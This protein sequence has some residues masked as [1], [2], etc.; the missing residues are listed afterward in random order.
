MNLPLLQFIAATF[1]M[2]V[3]LF[4]SAAIFVIGV[5]LGANLAQPARDE[6]GAQTPELDLSNASELDRAI[7]SSSARSSADGNV[8]PVPILLK[9][10]T[11]VESTVPVP[12]PS[13]NVP[14]EVNVMPGLPAPELRSRFGWR[15]W[16][17]RDVPNVS[18]QVGAKVSLLS[19]LFEWCIVLFCVWLFSIGFLTLGTQNPLSG[20]ESEIFQSLDWV[21]VNNLKNF[22][23]FPQWNPYIL[24]GLPYVGDPFLHLFNPLVTVPVLLMGV[25][26]GF[27]VG[28]FLSFVAAAFGAW[29]LGKVMG[30]GRT[31]RVFLALSYAF[32]GRAVAQFLQGQYD[33]IFSFSWIPLCIAGYIAAAETR[34]PFHVALTALAL[35][36]LFLSGNVYYTFYMIFV[37]GLFV[38]VYVLRV[39]RKPF[40]LQLN[41]DV[42]RALVIAGFLAVALSAVQLL[43][44]LQVWPNLQKQGDPTLKSSHTLSQVWLDYTS[45]QIERADTKYFAQETYSYIGYIPFVGLLLLPLAWFKQKRRV[46]V[47]MLL[48]FI[49]AVMWASGRETPL[50]AF[51]ESS[52]FLTQFR[53]PTRF[54]LYG[55]L[56]L[57][58]LT[59]LGLDSVLRFLPV[60]KWSAPCEKK[61]SGS[62]VAVATGVLL[63]LALMFWSVADVYMNNKRLAITLNVYEPAWRTAQAL[64][65]YDAS[66]NYVQTPYSWTGA[67]AANSHRNLGT[68]YGFSLSRSLQN[69]FSRRKLSL[70][71][72]YFI[73]AQNEK[74]A[75]PDPEPV[76]IQDGLVAYRLPASLPFAFVVRNSVLQDNNGGALRVGEVMP[77]TPQRATANV[78]DFE[79]E[80]PDAATLVVLSP[81]FDGWR[82]RVDGLAGELR[83]VDGYLGVPTQ[84]GT[85]RYAFEF[86]S[87]WFKVGL[88]ISL[89][90][91][92]LTGY[93]LVAEAL[94]LRVPDF[95]ST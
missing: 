24:T 23:E 66:P 5:R 9:A 82:V 64:R 55:A 76:L 77:V 56:A 80:A 49:F 69:N 18:S 74:P 44:F 85:H 95:A 62:H 75:Y 26:D 13:P 63:V 84:V 2:G 81:H 8:M 68:F 27:K 57:L 53:Y 16:V 58:S 21:L 48:L 25:L 46:L 11:R 78:L 36:L 87:L 42:L 51:F 43:P 28:V 70:Q 79:I 50:R 91:V 67:L 52:S 60:V 38:L 7:D 10:V 22:G 86:D 72:K 4:L 39:Q 40:A 71:A 90:A 17:A 34:R 6:K 93:L 45:T 94:K 14:S 83:N 37:F 59:V 88:V 35:A 92:V 89:A 73:L 3:V 31:G 19:T 32:T 33:L 12:V 54:L 29:Y 30:V 41:T 20:P 61:W 47:F 65:E 15:K 1:L